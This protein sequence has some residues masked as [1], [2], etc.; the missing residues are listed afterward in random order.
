MAKDGIKE[1][2]KM[3]KNRLMWKVAKLK[4]KTVIQMKIQ[5][6]G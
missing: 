5:Q 1:S 6:K 2:I 3:K 4:W